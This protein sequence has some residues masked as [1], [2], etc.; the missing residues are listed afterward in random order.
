MRYRSIAFRVF[1]FVSLAMI[2]GL[3]DFVTVTVNISDAQTDNQEIH[4]KADK[5]V[6]DLDNREM[7][8]LGNVRVTQQNTTV[9][10]DKMKVYYQESNSQNAEQTIQAAR[11]KVIA[12]GNVS[13][14]MDEMVAVT[15]A[16]TY[17]RD[18]ETLTLSGANSRLSNGPNSITGSKIIFFRTANKLIV[19]SSA[20]DPVKA[21]IYTGKSDLF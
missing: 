17:I 13:I 20:Q 12:N 1:I 3:T 18:T 11:S 10:A 19:E 8:L 14:E 2:M 4:I 6:A 21:L 15:D 9:N 16:A 7:E 5:I